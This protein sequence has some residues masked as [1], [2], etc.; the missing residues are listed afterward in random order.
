MGSSLGYKEAEYLVLIEGRRLRE[1]DTVIF[2]GDDKR[3]L[4]ILQLRGHSQGKSQNGFKRV[5]VFL[6]EGMT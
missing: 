2:E 5:G 3:W 6:L 4:K 1:F